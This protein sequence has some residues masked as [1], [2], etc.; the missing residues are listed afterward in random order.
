MINI[1]MDVLYRK[2]IK[3]GIVAGTLDILSAFTYYYLKTGETK[4]L[5]ILK[6][7]ASGI[8]GTEAFTGGTS[9]VLTGLAI[10]YFIAFSFTVLFFLLYP[11]LKFLSYNKFL[12]AI[13]Y[14]IFVWT[15]MNVII[16][17][18]SNAGSRPFNIVNALIN[19]IILIVC[20][21]MPLSLIAN[22]YFKS[23]R[24]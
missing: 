5:N 13:L 18:L 24:Q 11:K 23:E 4:F 20:I 17:P 3:A 10:H 8:Y 21:G 15:V 14:G 9:M 2:I 22:T 12:T 1:T 16:V 6:F 7:I 19:V